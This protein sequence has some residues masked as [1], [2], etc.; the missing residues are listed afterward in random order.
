MYSIIVL[1]GKHLGGGLPSYYMTF[2]YGDIGF[3]ADLSGEGLPGK[4]KKFY[5]SRE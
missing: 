1:E 4:K 3:Y 5:Y 2:S